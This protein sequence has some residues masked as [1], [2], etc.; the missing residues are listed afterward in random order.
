MF[1][2]PASRQF[3]IISF[4]AAD[5]RWTTSPAAILKEE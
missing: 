4:T 3:S 2:A 5:G 1:V